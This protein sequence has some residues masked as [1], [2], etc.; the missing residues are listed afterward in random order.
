MKRFFHNTWG[1]L[2]ASF[3]EFMSNKGVKLCAS[4]SYYTIFSL[5]PLLLIIISLSGIFFGTEAVQG[6]IYTQLEGL[7]G[8]RPAYQIQEAIKNITFSG[9]NLFAAIAGAVT[10][11][12]GAT[13]VFVEMQDSLNQIWGV[14]AKPSRGFLKLIINRLISFSMIV[15]LAFL[16]MV[17]LVIHALLSVLND[18]LKNILPDITVFLANALNTAIVLLTITALFSAIFKILPDGKLSWK[19]TLIGSLFTAVFFMIG[20]FAIGVYLGNSDI[21]SSYGAAGSLIIILLWVYYSAMILYFGA[22]FTKSYAM[23]FGRKIIPRKYAVLVEKR[24]T[25]HEPQTTA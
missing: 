13:G 12:I 8:S 14:K 19:D 6:Q 2:K 23:I 1:V 9:E 17:S 25:E 4:L 18:R 22:S 7:I 24:E 16:L 15:S 20:K 11:L 21:A 3:R 10:L 5:P